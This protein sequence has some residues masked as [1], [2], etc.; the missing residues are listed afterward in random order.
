[1]GRRLNWSKEHIIGF[2]LG[3]ILPLIG[4]YLFYNFGWG[5]PTQRAFKT[6]LSSNLG[7]DRILAYAYFVKFGVVTNI[8]P[9]LILNQLKKDRMM[10]G[11]IASTLIYGI[12]II[13]LILSQ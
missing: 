5:S 7:M 12:V 1:M 6:A 8:I 11:M 9:F 13:Y 2:A 10:A 3:L 4:S